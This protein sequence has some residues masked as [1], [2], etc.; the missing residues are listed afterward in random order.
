MGELLNNTQPQLQFTATNG[1]SGA[2]LL[3]VTFDI[4]K[5]S[6][7]T[8]KFNNNGR[9]E[10]ESTWKAVDNSTNSGGSGALSPAMVTV[11]N[12]VPTY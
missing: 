12:A 10:Y 1:L 2:N 8:V 9:I 3:S 4:Q 6:V 5:A 7:Q 11:V